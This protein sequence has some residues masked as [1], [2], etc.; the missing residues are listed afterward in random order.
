MRFTSALAS[1]LTLALGVT[2]APISDEEQV[3]L[4]QPWD[5]QCGVQTGPN[6]GMSQMNP[7]ER[8]CSGLCLPLPY[9]TRA[10]ELAELADDCHCM[11]PT[12]LSPHIASRRGSGTV[13]L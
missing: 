1:F 6:W 5:T 11:L 3:V 7:F 9:G 10:V 2:G 4:F 13:S 8:S 12:A